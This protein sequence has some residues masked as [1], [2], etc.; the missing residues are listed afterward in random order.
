MFDRLV[1]IH[2][3]RTTNRVANFVEYR[4]MQMGRIE[5]TAA[6]TL[7]SFALLCG[8]WWCRL[9]SS[10]TKSKQNGWDYGQ[11]GEFYHLSMNRRISLTAIR[12]PQ[13]PEE[14]IHGPH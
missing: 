2:E 3:T 6:A 11:L 7:R 1:K 8:K 14:G 4:Y 5:Y 13:A 9:R 12:S 10:N